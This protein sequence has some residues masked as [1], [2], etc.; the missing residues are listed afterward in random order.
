MVLKD[1]L[2]H[3]EKFTIFC[4]S[5]KSSYGS[6]VGIVLGTSQHLISQHATSELVQPL[7]SLFLCLEIFG[8]NIDA[9]TGIEQM[10]PL[11]GSVLKLVSSLKTLVIN[12]ADTDQE[13]ELPAAVCIP[14]LH[15][16]SLTTVWLQGRTSTSLIQS[17]ILSNINTL[18]T[19]WLS[20]CRP[21]SG[22]DFC[23]FCTCL[24]Q[25]TSLECLWWDDIDLSAHEEKELVSALE[26]ISS[27]KMVEYNGTRIL[28][29]VG[30]RQ[31]KQGMNSS[32]VFND[33]TYNKKQ[34]EDGLREMSRPLSSLL[35]DQ[36]THHSAEDEL[37]SQSAAGEQ[38]EDLQLA[39]ILS[40]S[41]Q[42]AQDE[43]R[44][45]EE[46]QQQALQSKENGLRASQS[47]AEQQDEDLQLA[48]TL[49]ASIQ[50]AQD[51]QR[52]REEGQQQA[53]QSDL[54]QDD[55][56]TKTDQ[57]KEKLKNFK[58]QQQALDEFHKDEQTRQEEEQ[59][60]TAAAEMLTSHHSVLEE[61]R[62]ETSQGENERALQTA[63]EHKN[64]DL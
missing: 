52:R 24:C 42:T 6:V 35:S 41:I 14:P 32:A 36:H 17:L 13:G 11:L 30:I 21:M 55:Q 56:A 61:Q 2:E 31:Y 49:S 15:C 62:S 47:A 63:A 9:P 45:I 4:G 22:S 50:T 19:I 58:E 48:L 28:T 10:I 7:S 57:N 33:G 12:S 53:L 20:E 18:I 46:E 5:T 54:S 16:P 40:A 39:L 26:Q 34:F 37:A 8:F 59:E 1:F 43:Q 64:A 23:N 38:D 29:D 3:F 51:E 27:L 25:S 44:R 60:A